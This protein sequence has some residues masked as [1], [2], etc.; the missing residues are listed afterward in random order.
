MYSK[1][2]LITTTTDIYGALTTFFVL[3]LT[4]IKGKYLPLTGNAC[5]SNGCKPQAVW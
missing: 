1:S 5:T 3:A 2:Q 4:Y